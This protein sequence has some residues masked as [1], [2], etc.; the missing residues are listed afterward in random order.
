MV[1]HLLTHSHTP[2]SQLH[3]PH[4]HPLFTPDFVA[5][6]N[7]LLGHCLPIVRQYA[8]RRGLDVELSSLQWG[9]AERVVDEH[10]VVP[11]C[12]EEIEACQRASAGACNFLCLL[13][14]KYGFRP[15]PQTL[16]EAAMQHAEK[17]LGVH[18]TE[19]LALL[20]TWYQ[21]DTNAAP[22]EYRLLPVS[23]VAARQPDL[24]W[25]ATSKQLVQALDEAFAP[26]PDAVATAAL[27]ALVPQPGRHTVTDASMPFG[28]RVPVPSGLL[29]EL[30]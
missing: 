2:S 1:L 16:S 21:L 7:H 28:I 17:R 5:E 29:N 6:R 23:V 14:D 11:I 3:S 19:R 30:H 22:P 27:E 8:Q 10:D 24:D 18:A 4:P 9:V 26:D 15:P 20:K 25:P 12:L 13:G